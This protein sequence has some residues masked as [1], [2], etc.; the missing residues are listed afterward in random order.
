MLAE[1]IIETITRAPIA[2]LI[3]D[4]DGTLVD[5]MRV[6]NNAWQVW[7][8]KNGFPFDHDTFFR[9]NAGRSNAEIVASLLPDM[10]S[11]EVEQFGRDKERVYREIYEPIM[12]PMPGLMDLIGT[13]HAKKRPMAVATAA[14]PAN[15]A[16]VLDGL[17]MRKYMVTCVSP[18][19][20]Y[21]GK[22]HPD[23]FLAAA[24]AMGLEPAQC[25]V[26]EDA[27]LGIEAA[28]RAGMRA[29]GVMTMLEREAFAFDNVVGAIADY[30]D[31]A[32]GKLLGL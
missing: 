19:M 32:L 10:P 23:L 15:A 27:P 6:H 22:P 4:M 20:G 17:D 30:T 26:F 14:P 12:A 2:G 29:V 9:E 21:R 25:L 16:L 7:Y 13:W 1:P 31:P 11:H 5:N 3:F 28:R 18:S 8:E 24:E